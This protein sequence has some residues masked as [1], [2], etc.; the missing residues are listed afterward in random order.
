LG[1]IPRKF[2][3]KKKEKKKGLLGATVIQ[4]NSMQND[5]WYINYECIKCC[6]YMYICHFDIKCCINLQCIFLFFYCDILLV[7]QYSG[8]FIIDYVPGF[9]LVMYQALSC[10]CTRHCLVYVPGIVLFMYQASFCIEFSCITVA[11][12]S[13]I[14]RVDNGTDVSLVLVCYMLIS[15]ILVSIIF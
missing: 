3:H 12:N 15:N 6:T 1:I 8:D 14:L 9:V 7:E 2:I 10:L 13:L 4:L 5:A 11:P